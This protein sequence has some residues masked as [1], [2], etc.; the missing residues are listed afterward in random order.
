MP[1]KKEDDGEQPPGD[2]KVFRWRY[3]ELR[4]RGIE[5]AEALDLAERP[6]VVHRIDSLLAKG[7]PPGLAARIV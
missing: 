7:C 6:D 1:D 2:D 5:H 3:R 4:K